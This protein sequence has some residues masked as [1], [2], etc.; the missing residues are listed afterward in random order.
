MVV[1]REETQV[2]LT[3]DE[4]DIARTH[5]LGD[6]LD[7]QPAPRFRAEIYEWQ[8]AALLATAQVDEAAKARI[9]GALGGEPL[10]VDTRRVTRLEQELRGS[11]WTTPSDA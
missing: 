9:V 10:T 2:T 4:P 6:R 5:E 11:L 8:I 3:N 7:R 1:E